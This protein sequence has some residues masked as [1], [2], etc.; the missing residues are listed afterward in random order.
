MYYMY[1]DCCYKSLS[2]DPPTNP[3][4]P[5]IPFISMITTHTLTLHWTPPTDNG[6]L[7]LTGY[8]VEVLLLGTNL[9]PQ[10][11]PEWAEHQIV[12][13]SKAIQVVVSGLVPYQQYQVRI[14]ARNSAFRSAPSLETDPV[15]SQPD[16]ER[17]VS[18]ECDV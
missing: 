8:V 9:C 2:V 12:E 7:P 5:T 13:D 17:G 16:G 3:S 18:L 11:E 6:N 1:I 14:R 10:S 15:W 4:P